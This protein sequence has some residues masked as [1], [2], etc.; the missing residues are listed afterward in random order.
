MP[1]ADAPSSLTIEDLLK[2]YERLPGTTVYF[3]DLINILNSISERDA[4]EDATIETL[5]ADISALSSIIAKNTKE[6]LYLHRLIAL[7]VF[8][9]I[10]QGIEVESKEL[11][12][13]FKT[14]I[15]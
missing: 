15:K 4:S 8:E 11:L 14:Y 10:E 2:I 12:N 7:L 6:I 9:L 1:S 5:S 13:E 3:T